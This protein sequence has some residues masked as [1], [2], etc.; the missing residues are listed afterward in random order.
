MVLEAGWDGV[1]FTGVAK[2]ARLT[3]GAVY[4]RAENPAELGID[5]WEHALGPWFAQAVAELF[6]AV[7]AND[8]EAVVALMEDWGS[9]DE[10]ALV[11]S[12]IHI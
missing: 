6:E 10:A 1:T 9:A 5:L 7:D 11:L 2:R 4:G 12:L 3:V 8:P